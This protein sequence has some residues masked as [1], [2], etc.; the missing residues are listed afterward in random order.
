MRRISVVLA[1]ALM[2]L[3]AAAQVTDANKGDC[4]H[5][6]TDDVRIGACTAL[7]QSG[8][9]SAEDLAITYVNRGVVYNRNGR[10][11]EALAD[12]SSALSAQPN[13]ANAYG[14]RATAYRRKEQFDMA[15][16]DDSRGIA[17]TGDPHIQSILY[18]DRGL[19][20]E[21]KKLYDLALADM[22]KAIELKADSAIYYGGRARVYHRIGSDA[23]ALPDAE[24]AASLRPADAAIL[25]TRAEV[26]EKLGRRDDAVAGYRA[27]L[28]IDSTVADARAGLTRLGAAP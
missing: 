24:K 11:D 20:Q 2:V 18:F 15:I 8:Q 9:L 6:A 26:Y 3:P 25:E 22:N 5:G 4:A 17:A 27:V 16:A 21:N 23:Q 1:T 14:V 7:I 10:P 12:A 13:Y 19:S 28:Q